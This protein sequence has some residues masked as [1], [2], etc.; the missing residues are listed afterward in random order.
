MTVN[1]TKLKTLNRLCEKRFD[2]AKKISAIDMR[3]AH[4]NDLD[5]ELG[6]IL[7]L[8]DAIRE[9]REL[10]WLCDGKDLGKEGK[11]GAEKNSGTGN[12]TGKRTEETGRSGGNH[13]GGTEE[14][15]LR[16]PGGDHLLP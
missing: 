10:A 12:S 4:E 7:A 5:D 6:G 16:T 14:A 1:R 11:N 9:R 8:Q 2:T 15:G 3:T 13:E